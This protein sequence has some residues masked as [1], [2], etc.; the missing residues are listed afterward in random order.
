MEEEEIDPQKEL[1]VVRSVVDVMMEASTDEMEVKIVNEGA[2]IWIQSP[3]AEAVHS[4]K[5]S[6]FTVKDDEMS[7]N[8][9]ER[10][11]PFPSSVL[12]LR[13]SRNDKLREQPKGR[14]ADNAVPSP[15]LRR[16]SSKTHPFMVALPVPESGLLIKMMDLERV[17]GV[18]DDDSVLSAK[19][20]TDVN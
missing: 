10:A 19:I 15:F 5:L 3:L 12:Q 4:K 8:V 9:I 20:S 13:N 6:E 14:F 17:S 1:S 18:N 11:P 2:L 16:K 7:F